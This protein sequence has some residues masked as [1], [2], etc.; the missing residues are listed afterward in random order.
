MRLPTHTANSNRR[1]IAQHFAPA[2]PG[3]YEPPDDAAH[4][5]RVDASEAV[6]ARE[7]RRV[8]LRRSSDDVWLAEEE[9][10][11]R[12][13][14][15]G[16]ELHVS[17]EH[18]ECGVCFEPLCKERTAVFVDAE[19]KRVCSHFL[20]D[21]CARSTIEYVGRW[22]PLCRAECAESRG[23]PFT[24]EDA[25]EWF[26]L[27]DVQGEGTMNKEQVISVIRAQVPVDWKRIAKDLDS[28]WSKF[29]PE[30]TGVLRKDDVIGEQGLL[31]MVSE[32]YP[33]RLREYK[34]IPHVTDKSRW[35]TFWD[36]DLSGMLE[37]DEV[38]RALI[39]S[40]GLKQDVEHIQ[41][42]RSVVENIWCVFDLDDS[43]GIDLT[44]FMI[45]DGLGDAIVAAFAIDKRE[46]FEAI[47]ARNKRKGKK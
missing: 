21:R 7:R 10:G 27:C 6:V 16:G 39:K 22:C 46:E 23:V 25:D 31:K 42:L 15:G 14:K 34:S 17:E 18:Q 44:E 12:S 32:K 19:G 5:G 26:R 30:D 1:Q 3:A 45:E 11:S 35:F 20:H 38:V 41:A 37:K 29:D 2:I 47:R 13:G 43:G 24:T 9:E 33:A 36:E 28:L 4:R 40:F 8:F